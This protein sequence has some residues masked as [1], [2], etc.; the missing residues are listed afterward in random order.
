MHYNYSYEMAS[1]IVMCLLLVH[2]IAYKQFPSKRTRLFLMFL[3]GSILGSAVN[4]FLGVSNHFDAEIPR[5]LKHILAFA[6]FGFQGFNYYMFYYYSLYCCELKKK[7]RRNLVLA[8]SLP[9]VFLGVLLLLTP[10]TQYL[11]YIDGSGNIQQGSAHIFVYVNNAAYLLMEVVILILGTKRIR[12]Y[13]KIVIFF[14]TCLAVGALLMEFCMPGLI[15]EG[16]VRV[17]ILLLLYLSMQNQGEMTDYTSKLGNRKALKSMIHSCIE[18]KERITIVY[19]RISKMNSLRMAMGNKSSHELTELLGSFF[20]ECGSKYYSF[21][22]ETNEFAIFIQK[23]KRPIDETVER[24]QARFQ[25]V[26]KVDHMELKLTPEIVVFDYPEHFI[27]LE[28]LW[29][30]RDYMLRYLEENKQSNVVVADEKLMAEYHKEIE[31]E[32]ALNRASKHKSIEVEYQPIYSI[33]DGRITAAEALARLRDE[34]GKY[35]SPMEFIPLAEKSNMIVE[36]GYI[37]FEKVCMFIQKELLPRP[38]LGID[39]IHVNLSTI[40][41]IQEDMADHFIMIMNKYNVPPSMIEFEV[42][43][44]ITMTFTSLMEEHMDKL[45]RAG[46]HFS[47]DDYGTGSSNCS[48]LIDFSFRTVKFDKNMMSAF[49]HSDTANI[50][51]GNEISTANMLGLDIVAEGIE[52]EE[53]YQRLRQIEVNYIQGYYFS[54]P[55]PPDGFVEYVSKQLQ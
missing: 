55:L 9:M 28:E 45:T 47:L 54:R 33:K 19:V 46:A 30:M 14:Y 2:F 36:L 51:I 12:K 16:L 21:R 15:L 52:T 44:T 34:N 26:W 24:I 5:M 17:I 40:Q 50:I 3:M 8:G 37:I 23:H 53:E 4:L 39:H 7:E 25:K 32:Q 29:D 43:E 18:N 20:R 42:T 41:C 35:I 38:E 22:V 48:Y 27:N 6:V 31:V 49:F 11:Y 13:T 1:C 10:F